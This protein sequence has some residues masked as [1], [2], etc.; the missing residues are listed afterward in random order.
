MYLKSE[1]Q[2]AQLSFAPYATP[3]KSHNHASF[4]PSYTKAGN[5]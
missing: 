2:K 4:A 3:H 5:P 1:E